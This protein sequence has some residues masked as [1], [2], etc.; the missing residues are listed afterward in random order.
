MSPA[1]GA[2]VAVSAAWVVRGAEAVSEL[3]DEGV[4]AVHEAELAAL[5]LQR[6]QT[7]VEPDT[8]LNV[9]ILDTIF[10]FIEDGK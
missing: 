1:R 2:G 9:G 4:L 6:Q 5:V 8:A 7:S 10:I 3:V